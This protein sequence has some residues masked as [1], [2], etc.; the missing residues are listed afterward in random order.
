MNSIE[1]SNRRVEVSA[2]I[3]DYVY[4]YEKD[5]TFRNPQNPLAT[6]EEL[7]KKSYGDSLTIVDKMYDKDSGVAAIAV[8][9]KVTE[10]TYISYAGTNMDADGHKDPIVD[11]AIALNDSLYL[12]EKSKPAL[13][14][15]DRV[16]ASG[17]QITTTTGHSYG[18]F[19]GGRV[20]LE[21][22]VLS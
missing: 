17:H 20:A 12:K 7:I 2:K 19:H 9:D 10:E 15:Y 22:Q 13:D 1:T 16:E 14:F 6:T 3:S 8:Y 4:E 21:R 18:E 5:Y 11:L